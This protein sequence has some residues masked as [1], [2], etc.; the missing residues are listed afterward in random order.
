MEAAAAFD[1][2]HARQARGSVVLNFKKKRN[3]HSQQARALTEH[4][5]VNPTLRI[6]NCQMEATPYRKPLRCLKSLMKDFF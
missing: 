3:R 5:Y 2:A 4:S 1:R 6:G